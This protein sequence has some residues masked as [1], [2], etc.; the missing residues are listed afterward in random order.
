MRVETLETIFQAYGYEP[1]TWSGVGKGWFPILHEMLRE[2]Q[3]CGAKVRFDQVKEK[4]G[5]LR[6]YTSHQN[7]VVH[8]IIRQAE[9]CS[10][11]TCEVCGEPG[12]LNDHE[13]AT[14]LS[15]LCD[16]CRNRKNPT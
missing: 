9:Q 7:S 11:T 15:T 10:R 8:E 2:L 3:S 14:W 5:T 4:F 13:G 6:V 16:P 12:K 1:P